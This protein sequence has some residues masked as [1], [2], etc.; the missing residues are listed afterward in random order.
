MAPPYPTQPPNR[1]TARK[2]AANADA[3]YSH[4]AA[5]PPLSAGVGPKMRRPTKSA[6]RKERAL[7]ATILAAEREASR[8][9]S[10]SPSGRSAET[11]QRIRPLPRRIAWPRGGLKNAVNTAVIEHRAIPASGRNRISAPILSPR[12]KKL[13]TDSSACPIAE[14]SASGLKS[15]R[16][17]ATTSCGNEAYTGTPP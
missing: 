11:E 15:R 17:R 3:R 7:V 13:I 8:G 14:G 6:N 4:R 10:G 5:G 9:Y 1:H 12:M 16:V 2:G